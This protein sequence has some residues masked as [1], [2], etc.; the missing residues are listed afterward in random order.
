M[1]V[2]NLEDKGTISPKLKYSHNPN[3]NPNLNPNTKPNPNYLCFILEITA[4]FN[5]EF[6]YR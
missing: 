5:F 4:D 3:H 1:H 2:G 6:Y